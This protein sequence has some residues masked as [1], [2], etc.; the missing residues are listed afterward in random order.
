MA[1]W[2]TAGWYYRRHMVGQMSSR[3]RG[4]GATSRAASD[5]IRGKPMLSRVTPSG[6]VPMR[7]SPWRWYDVTT[8]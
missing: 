7:L 6:A 5:R 2:C 8:N 3:P 1:R 4:G